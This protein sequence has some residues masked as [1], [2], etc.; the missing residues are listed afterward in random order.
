[1]AWSRKEQDAVNNSPYSDLF[2]RTGNDWHLTNSEVLEHIMWTGQTIQYIASQQNDSEEKDFTTLI[3]KTPPSKDLLEASLI[4]FSLPALEIKPEFKKTHTFSWVSDIAYKIAPYATFGRDNCVLQTKTTLTSIGCLQ[5]FV[6][7]SLKNEL[8]RDAGNRSEVTDWSSSKKKIHVSSLELWPYSLDP[9]KTIQLC[10]FPD[11]NE[12][13]HSYKFALLTRKLLN[14]RCFDSTTK[15]FVD[16]EVTKKL[17]SDIFVNFPI[18]IT[19]P[20][21]YCSFVQLTE[22]E[23]NNRKQHTRTHWLYDFVPLTNNPAPIGDSGLTSLGFE[24]RHLTTA[25][26]FG[27]ENV[28][29]QAYN[30]TY[31]YTTKTN[32]NTDKNDEGSVA[33]IKHVSVSYSDAA[34][35]KKFE[36]VPYRIFNSPLTTRKSNASPLRN[37]ICYLPFTPSHSQGVFLGGAYTQGTK[38]TIQCKAV[39]QK[40]DTSSK[41]I[42]QGFAVV[43]RQTNIG[44]DGTVSFPRE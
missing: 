19:K 17:C 39:S 5:H 13:F 21:L 22:E 32:P 18:S 24:N 9:C 27:L 38:A 31:S 20:K 30:H 35:T 44:T 7:E 11:S 36:N 28:T 40:S 10:L 6:G 34:S 1:M 23:R 43:L 16:L 25:V 8:N 41:Y 3:F 42:L 15:K 33:S 26:I 14:I 2:R 29:G 37:G 4:D 12:T